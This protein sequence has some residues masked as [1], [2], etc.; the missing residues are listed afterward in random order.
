MFLNVSL[1][2]KFNSMVKI[3]YCNTPASMK[4]MSSR[5]LNI[6]LCYYFPFLIT[7]RTQIPCWQKKITKCFQRMHCISFN[8]FHKQGN[9]YQV[10]LH[11]LT[12]CHGCDYTTRHLLGS[13]KT[14]TT[15]FWT[16]QP[17]R[18]SSS[19]NLW[20]TNIHCNIVVSHSKVDSRNIFHKSIG[21]ISKQSLRYPTPWT[22]STI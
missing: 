8:I 7:L 20:Q 15:N 13:T 9:Q 6:K 17:L 18:C 1:I 19:L 5:N 12:M 4:N 16:V 3:W 11:V 22:I 10:Y 2:S 21:P 14:R